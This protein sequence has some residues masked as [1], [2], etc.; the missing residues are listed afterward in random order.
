MLSEAMDLVLFALLSF[1]PPLS[2]LDLALERLSSA[3]AAERRAAER[4]LTAH[5]EREHYPRLAETAAGGSREVR[6]RLADAL[7]ADRNLGLSALL[8][9]EDEASLRELG[10]SAMRRSLARWYEASDLEWLS[11]A[12]VTGKFEG[13][14]PSAYRLDPTAEGFD[15]TLDRIARHA[16][17]EPR[18]S[19]Q[20]GPVS[21]VAD[22]V[23]SAHPPRRPVDSPGEIVEDFGGLVSETAEAWGLRLFV[24]GF[25][26]PHP[27]AFVTSRAAA[28]LVVRADGQLGARARAV[29]AARRGSRAV[30]GQQRLAGGAELDRGALAR[31]GGGC[32]SRRAHDR[33]RSRPR[34]ARTGARR[35]GAA[36]ARPRRRSGRAHPDRHRGHGGEWGR[37]GAGPARGLGRT[38][39]APARLVHARAV[40]L[41]PRPRAA[42]RRLARAARVRLRTDL[43]PGSSD[44]TVR[45]GAHLPRA[46][47]RPAPE[48][49][50][51]AARARPIPRATGTD[52]GVVAEAPG[53][54]A[55][56]VARAHRSRDPA[57]PPGPRDRR[58]APGLLATG[59]PD[60][61]SLARVR[62][63]GTASGR[64]PL[65][66]RRA[67]GRRAPTRRDLGPRGRAT[68][69]VPSSANAWRSW[70]AYPCPGRSRP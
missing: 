40:R 13:G 35:F 26:T 4:W 49:A 32:L 17:P 48:L 46:V 21:V 5:L 8:I 36:A 58:L 24:A 28:A 6:T 67:R 42:A 54:A 37:P 9:G 10:E 31:L 41:G 51:G 59:G 25:E 27:V 23:A 33:G 55:P 44:R 11:P 70:P 61:G 62:H 7:S 39:R 50:C 60:H 16:N 29:G 66:L 69:R 57:R 22:P 18:E 45:P 20:T 43:D 52:A 56:V 12:D 47:A 3:R 19:P 68:R 38:R 1:A 34:G 64:G 53:P 65:P 14:F 2:D 63:R 15:L 30:P